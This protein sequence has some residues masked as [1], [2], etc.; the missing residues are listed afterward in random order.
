M[1]EP[2]GDGRRR[3]SLC[4]SRPL[5]RRTLIRPRFPTILEW[6]RLIAAAAAR[7]PPSIHNDG[8]SNFHSIKE[9]FD[10]DDDDDDDDDDGDHDS[11]GNCNKHSNKKKTFH[12]ETIIYL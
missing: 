11:S 10:Y 12:M 7:T 2:G 9:S 1:G 6:N 3:H 5:P 4:H 8:N